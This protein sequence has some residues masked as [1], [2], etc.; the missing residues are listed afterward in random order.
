M[1]IRSCLMVTA[2]LVAALAGN[3]VAA[4]SAGAAPRT[5]VP[6][7]RL[8]LS[9]ATQR[10]VRMLFAK[11][12]GIPVA[13]IAGIVPAAVLGP[14][15]DRG[16]DWMMIGFRPSARAPVTVKLK[17]Q[18]GAG[19]GV[20]TR[21]TGHAWTL[22]GL[23][24]V[25]AGCGVAI[26]RSVRRAWH[27]PSCK[28]S[29]VPPKLGIRPA[30]AT[31][32]SLVDI[33]LAQVGVAD[34]PASTSFSYDCNP[35]TTLVGN[36]DGAGDCGTTTSN[37]S[38]FSGVENANEQWC[39]DFTKWVWETDGVTSDL[40]T[41]T[42]SS[43][44]FYNWAVDQ[45]ESISFGGTPAVG[46]A[47]LFYPAGTS[48]PNGSYADH[49]GIV[50]AVNSNGSVNL[51][52]GDF[53]GS[54]NISV[55]YNTDVP[56]PSW[57]AAGEEWAFVSPQLA[58]IPSAYAFWEGT[59]GDLWEG[60]G[61]ANG[62]LAGPYNRGMGPLGSTPTAGVDAHG[63]TY[64]YWRGTGPQYD[65]WEAYWNGSGWVGPY[66]RGMGPLGS[67][68]SV[69]ITPDGTA[70]VFWEG[71]NGDLWEAQGP[72]DGSLSGPYNRG[73]GP[74][75]SAPTAGVD[76]NGA[77][78]VYWEGTAPGYNLWEGYWN[79]SGWVGPYNLGM[80]PLGSQPSAA[81]TLNGTA[82]VFWEGTQ[83]DLWEAQGPAD[84]SL[85]GPYNRGM[86]PLGSAP[87]AGVGVN[88]AT[89][90]YWEGTGPGYDLWEGYWNGS[91][92]VGPYNRGMGPLGTPPTVAIY[93]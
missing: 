54:S 89:Y 5:A 1:R 51:V 60:Q 59:Q 88:G 41:L 24:G 58:S 44:S 77:T 25:P 53:L 70:Y 36:P 72:A 63:A 92:W 81:V 42:P 6:A 85:S 91:G 23:G 26:P 69:A 31:T 47:V 45:G 30:S 86:G 73:M 75:G 66:N 67:Q 62:S 90:V 55:Q 15:A 32:G 16:R 48:A 71:T 40:G 37:G 87:A 9:P 83:G 21:R 64:V 20:F 12:R 68:P 3:W 74:L 56:G 28:A 29:A 84:G 49:V 8:A 7:A 4:G 57:Y 14:R 18:D 27:L 79:G 19:T 11:D 50:T 93:G 43:A 2:A 65:L 34:N 80:G 33:A 78:Y 10:H 17:F 52:D 35:Y 76:A 22:A 38:W 46:D 39:A 61:L 82:Y 13:D